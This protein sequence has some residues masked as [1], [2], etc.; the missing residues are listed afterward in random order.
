MEEYEDYD[1]PNV[2]EH[3]KKVFTGVLFDIFQWE[4]EMFDGS[5]RTF[6]KVWRK[7]TVQIIAV[8]K[9]KKLVLLNEEQ[10]GNGK[11][12]SFPGGQV[13]KD[14]RILESVKKELS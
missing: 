13:E 2:P 1:K 5:K 9:E 12:I 10:P 14:E 4:Q 8:T 11:F 7:P 3:S 6:E